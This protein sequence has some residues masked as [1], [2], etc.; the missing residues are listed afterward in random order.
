MS[1][2]KLNR[3]ELEY[4]SYTGPEAREF[5]EDIARLRISEFKPYPYLYDGN[6]SCERQ[7][8]ESYFVCP[9]TLIILVFDQG[10]VVGF[11]S[12]IPL[13]ADMGEIK[14]TFVNANYNLEQ[15]LYI[16]EVIIQDPY[17]RQGALNKFLEEHGKH[18]QNLGLTKL[19]AM[20]VDRPA[21]H[22][23][24]PKDYFPTELLFEK[25]GWRDLQI[26]IKLK[27]KQVDTGQE[28]NNTLS[29]WGAE[30]L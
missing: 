19:T 28:E 23:L 30:V 8:L 13:V 22:T 21:N 15:W 16:G 10:Q 12:S 1:I 11:S 24:K 7:Y 4:K 17:Q 6:I 5:F 29:F 20:F 26:D 9:D 3:A 27:W 25:K 18:A 14:N 2:P